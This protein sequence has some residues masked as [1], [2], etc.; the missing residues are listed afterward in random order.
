MSA[1]QGKFIGYAR[2]S[3]ADQSTE[4]QL[5]DLLAAGLRKD[6]LYIDHG[7][8]GAR[9]KRPALEQCMAAL[10]PGDTLVVATLDRLGRSTSHMLQLSEELQSREIS[11]RV[12]NLGGEAVDT[13]TPMGKM[14]F[15]VMVAL[16]QMELAIKQE[17]IQDS[18]T[19]RQAKGG[20]LGGRS[21]SISDDIIHGITRDIEQGMSVSAAVRK[22]KGLSRATYYRR[23]KELEAVSARESTA[24]R[25]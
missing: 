1:P 15:T 9:D 5:D 13:S 2:V 14:L 7:V 4:R 24:D 8:S 23:I 22:R 11:L 19:K 21:Q 6:D 18:I 10:Q 3:T 16:A 17:R 20:N 12:L 25:L